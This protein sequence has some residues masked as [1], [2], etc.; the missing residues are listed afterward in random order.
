LPADFC[1]IAERFVASDFLP[2]TQ[3]GKQLRS[4]PMPRPF[5]Q[6]ESEAVQFFVEQSLGVGIATNEPPLRTLE[7]QTRVVDRVGNTLGHGPRGK[8]R[9][10]CRFQHQQA[11]VARIAHQ[12]EDSLLLQS[13]VGGT[14]GNWLE[15]NSISNSRFRVGADKYYH[16]H[17]HVPGN[18][19]QSRHWGRIVVSTR[20]IVFPFDLFGSPGTSAGASL[21]GDALREMLADNRRETQPSRCRAYQSHV[22]LKEFAFDTLDGVRKWRRTARTAARSALGKGEFLLW[23]GGNHLSVLPVFEELGAKAGAI[24]VQF[25]AHLDVYNLAGCSEDLSHGNFLLHGESPLPPILHVGHRDLFLP[26]DHTAKHFRAVF[27]AEQLA[28]DLDAVADRIRAET[29]RAERVWIDIDCDV[30][31]PAFFPAVTHAQPFG[32][33][34]VALMRLI[35]P[36]WSDRVVGVSVSEFEPGRDRADQSLA[37]LVWLLEWLLLKRYE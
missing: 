8:P 9:E 36:V 31:D 37:T 3:V 24:V 2:V 22:R 12:R 1:T 13:Q 4:T 5:L 16:I 26:R 7:I 20:V 19:C 35:D 29:R 23:L 28:I 18:G 11:V 14:L 32:M 17:E 21:M 25:D 30:F 27:P 33:A 34:P 10:I 6:M 15:H